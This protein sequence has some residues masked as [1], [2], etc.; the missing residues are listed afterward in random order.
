MTV[1]NK[2]ARLRVTLGFVCGIAALWLSRPTRASMLAGGIVAIVGEAVRVW[3]AGHLE[4]GREVTSSG[5]Y[6]YTRHPLYAGSTLIGIGLGVASHSPIVALLAVAYLAVTI[7]A[8]IRT[9]EAHLTEKFGAAYPEY[10]SGKGPAAGRRFSAARAI[11]NRDTARSP[12]CWSRSACWRGRRGC[13]EAARL[14]RPGFVAIIRVCWTVGE[15]G[16]A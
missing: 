12:G 11:R 4:K 15:P 16:R 1:L 2:I 5:P 10:R 9:E 6:A 14:P 7:T 13:S 3:A 8:A